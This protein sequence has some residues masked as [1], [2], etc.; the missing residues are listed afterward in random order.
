ML[1]RI[2]VL[3]LIALPLG[4]PAFAQEASPTPTVDVVDVTGP[5]DRPGVAYII[6]TIEESAKRGS[7]A[8]I[9][10]ID[11]P[12][13]VGGDLDRLLALVSNPPVPVIAWIGD[14]PAVAYGGGLW[15]ALA[16]PYTV[17]AP[18]VEIGYPSP[19]VLGGPPTTGLEVDLMTVDEPVP[20]LIDAVEATLGGL[21]VS[22]D[23]RAMPTAN[24]PVTLATA[25]Q[26]EDDGEMRTTVLPEVRFLEPGVWTRTLRL[27]LRP[28]AI[29]F[30]L[31]AGLAFAAF[32]FYAIGPGVAA[33][34]ATLPM[35]LAGYGLVSLPIGWGL[36]VVLAAMWLLSADFQRGG[37]GRLSYVATALLLVGGLFITDTRPALPSATWAIVLT[38]VGIGLFYMIAMPTVARSR[39]TTRTI[40]REY[41]VGRSGVAV[42]D[43]PGFGTVE[44]DG[45]RWQAVS[46]RE[47]GITAGDGVVVEGV[48]GVYLE[49]GPG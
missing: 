20:G 21:I 46:H 44:V 41:L 15:L 30:F 13:V 10:Q 36:A 32:E 18:G 19:A 47:S 45:A 49:V 9:L 40:G 25:K 17:A 23:G 35:L 37:F 39:F 2:F 34:T 31:A 11:V 27:A 8:V 42:T 12:A 14:S 4:V 1:R 26:V 16:A 48:Q 7:V 28:E 5:L 24:G 6:E 22:L 43:L 3:M 33:A 29:F 38:A